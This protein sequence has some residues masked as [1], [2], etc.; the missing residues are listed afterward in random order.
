VAMIVCPSCGK[1]Q[2][3]DSSRKCYAC[4]VQLMK[5]GSSVVVPDNYSLDE[6]GNVRSRTE[7]EV[8]DSKL[9]VSYHYIL[10]AG[11]TTLRG[12]HPKLAGPPKCVHPD[13]LSCNFGDGFARCDLMLYADGHWTCS[14]NS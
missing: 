2:F 1:K 12:E 9:Y 4:K 11:K 7:H 8:N 5:D 6:Y 13:R 10:E 3:N 14:S